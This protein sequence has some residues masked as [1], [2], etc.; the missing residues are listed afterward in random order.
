MSDHFLPPFPLSRATAPRLRARGVWCD[1]CLFQRSTTP[2]ARGTHEQGGTGFHV[3][4]DRLAASIPPLFRE[5][6]PRHTEE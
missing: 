3:R 6:S 4:P 5:L 2:P 1:W